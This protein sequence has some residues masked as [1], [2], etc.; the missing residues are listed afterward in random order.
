MIKNTSQPLSTSPTSRRPYRAEHDFVLEVLANDQADR[1][2]HGRATGRVTQPTVKA[3]LVVQESKL[4]RA[5]LA[6]PSKK[7]VSPKAVGEPMEDVKNRVQV[8]LHLMHRRRNRSQFWSKI[9]ITLLL[10]AAMLT[11]IYYVASTFSS[12]PGA[13][14]LNGSLSGP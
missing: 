1:S 6:P 13:R 7:V 2:G 5:T 11:A 10:T 9:A 8:K 14:V 4:S 12:S 3:E